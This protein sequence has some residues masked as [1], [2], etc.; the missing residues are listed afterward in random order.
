MFDLS[1][2]ILTKLLI[3][4]GRAVLSTKIVVFLF[5]TDYLQ[6]LSERVYSCVIDMSQHR[7]KISKFF[8]EER[9]LKTCLPQKL[10]ILARLDGS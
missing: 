6:L 2:I 7:E 5:R 10:V 4:Y 8:S 3:E 9:T 1:V